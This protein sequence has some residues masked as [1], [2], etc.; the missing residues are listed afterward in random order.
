MY[1]K[2]APCLGHIIATPKVES[3]DFLTINKDNPLLLLQ[4]WTRLAIALIGGPW[5]N[6]V[7]M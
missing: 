7:P 2:D 5:M 3:V 6:F 4:I 1:V